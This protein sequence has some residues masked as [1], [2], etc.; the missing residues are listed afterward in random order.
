MAVDRL[1][2]ISCIRDKGTM[3]LITSIPRSDTALNRDNNTT[4]INNWFALPFVILREWQTN[5]II[6]NSGIAQMSK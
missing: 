4:R 1:H 5:R 6:K 3:L 2:R